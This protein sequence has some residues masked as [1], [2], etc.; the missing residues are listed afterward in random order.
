MRQV[1]KF[2]LTEK[3]MKEF[4]KWKSQLP[5]MQADVFG[6]DFV[7]EFIFYPT[8]LGAVKKVRRIDGHELELTDFE[9]W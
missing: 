4:E 2:E 8:G 1:L 7:F 3:E 5:T 9:D 6:D